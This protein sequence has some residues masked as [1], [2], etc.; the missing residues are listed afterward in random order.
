MALQG[1]RLGPWGTPLVL[2]LGSTRRRTLGVCCLQRLVHLMVDWWWLGIG[3][4]LR[5]LVSV[6]SSLVAM[7][8]LVG[9]DGLAALNLLLRDLFQKY[10][11][12]L[13]QPAGAV[14]PCHWGR[15]MVAPVAFIVGSVMS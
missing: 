13:L 3:V 15:G 9:A 12:Y 1:T 2:R 10:T 6:H 14:W 7:V 8:S 5:G 11:Q 4:R